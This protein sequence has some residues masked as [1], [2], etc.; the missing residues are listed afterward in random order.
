MP[1]VKGMGLLMVWADVPDEVEDEFNRWY[2]E[3]HIGDILAI[4]GVLGAARYT[5]VRGGPAKHLACYEL[6]SPG[7]VESQQFQSL[8]EDP[9]EWSKR[10]S[11]RVVGTNF[12]FNV[13]Q[14][15]FP[16]TVPQDV[17]PSDMAPALQIGRMDVPSE[18]DA[19]FNEW[20]NTIYV[21]NY[22]KVSG[23][24]SG[25]RY[26]VVQGETQ[27]AAVYELEDTDVSLSA[28]WA[29]TRDSHP[30]S[31]RIRSYMV[32]GPGSPGVYKKIF[33]L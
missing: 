25:R 23:C 26:R 5:T 32:H 12:I 15:I 24:I 33:P 19:E 21:P 7:V 10:M 9:S 3:E 29:A 11:P 16:G 17:A 8:R 18:V 13:Y 20:Y 31:D 1:N 30:Q 22:E 4:P 27:Y 2:N 6:E 14:Q 28:D